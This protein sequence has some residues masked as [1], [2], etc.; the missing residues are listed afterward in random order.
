MSETSITRSHFYVISWVLP[1]NTVFLVEYKNTTHSSSY[2][3][4]HHVVFRITNLIPFIRK[5]KQ[6]NSLK[7]ACLDITHYKSYVNRPGLINPE[8]RQCYCFSTISTTRSP[9]RVISGGL[10]LAARFVKQPNQ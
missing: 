2:G 6:A 3:G 8:Q 7:S 4:S 1:G 5:S 10:P 9:Y